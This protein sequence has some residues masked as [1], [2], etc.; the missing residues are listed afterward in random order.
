MTGAL[1]GRLRLWASLLGVMGSLL[2]AGA[3][4]AAATVTGTQ[5][6]GTQRVDRT[7]YDYTYR[8]VVSNGTPALAAATATVR[9]NA[10][11]TQVIKGT[12]TLGDV[13]AGATVTS[14]DTFTIRQERSVTFNPALLV[15]TVA[16]AAASPTLDVGLADPVVA[17]GGQVLVTPTL[18]DA[19]GVVIDS[20]GQAFALTVTPVG[21]VAGAAPVVNGLAVNFP[22]LNKRLLS[23]DPTLDPNGE[24]ADTDPADPQYGKETGGIYR[25]T[26]TMAGSALSSSKDVVVLPS[27]SA[28]IT[29]TAN[30]YAGALGGLLLQA[31]QGIVNG[32][33]VLTEQARAALRAVDSTRDYS[34]AVLSATQSMVP[35]DGGALTPALLTANGFAPGAQDAA[36]ASTLAQ[37][38]TRLVQAR[39]LLEATNVTALTQT[40]VD[41]LQAAAL[42]YKQG[43]QALQTLKPSALGATQQQAAFNQALAVEVPKLLDTIKRKAG[44]LL[45]VTVTSAAAAAPVLTLTLPDLPPLP[46]LGAPTPAAMYAGTR[47][48]QLYTFAATMFGIL[49][50]LSGTARG[51]IIELS[52]TLANSLLNIQL[53]NV[54][55]RNGAGSMTLD[56]C[57]GSASF[58]YVCPNYTPSR[59][60][61]Y[62]F[63]RDAGAVKVALVG[64]V[65]SKQLRDL[66]TLRM[67]KDLAAGIRLINKL[68]SLASSLQQ[69]GGVAAVV[70]PD[71]IQE[72]PFGLADDMMYFGA[73]WPR[74]NQGRLPCVGTVIVMNTAKGGIAAVNVNFLGQ[75]G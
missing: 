9:S 62:G 41:A 47:P 66:I 61:G 29:V 40:Q 4:H 64:C 35:P 22:K 37:L 6:V 31:Q 70:V 71:Y 7:V 73:G 55:N 20:S 68:V 30:R 21:P 49:T 18:R 65:N 26:V 19:N 57:L 48:V 16:S 32:N 23:P 39:T 45:G 34:H 17:P 36:F 27:G 51:N 10:A 14:S 52:I 54:I 13:A 11:A 15:W 53:A 25:L 2:C 67:P 28:P 33:A 12:V 59:I 42:A 72:D 58:A 24:F 74:V 43:L 75:C 3:A 63:G 56:Y 50:D 60:G 44:D 69:E 5:L 46:G 38:N 1:K 8:I